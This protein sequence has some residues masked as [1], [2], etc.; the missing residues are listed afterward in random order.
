[1]RFDGLRLVGDDFLYL[2]R[3]FFR[4][5]RKKVGEADFYI[6]FVNFDFNCFRLLYLQIV[7]LVSDVEMFDHLLALH[8]FAVAV[9][10]ENHSDKRKSNR[11]R[12]VI[13]QRSHTSREF[14]YPAR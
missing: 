12:G 10:Y 2:C 8:G 14:H 1:M 7:L 6:A 4:S 9:F 3:I 13:E 11:Y 5:Q